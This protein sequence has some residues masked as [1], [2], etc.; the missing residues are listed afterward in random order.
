MI[1]PN[2][3]ILCWNVRGL[4]R[5]DG[6]DIVHQTI[7]A[8]KHHIACLQESKLSTL[9]QHTA[10]YLGDFRLH[11]FVIKLA[12][13]VFVMCGGIVILWNDDSILLTN[14]V[15]GEFHLLADI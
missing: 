14:C 1:G 2:A 10:A 13:G 15:M 11:N 12:T 6:K 5:R 4:N 9:D 7:A 8:T 3:D